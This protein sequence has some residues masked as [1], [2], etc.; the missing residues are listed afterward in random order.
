[1]ASFEA[2]TVSEYIAL[3]CCVMFRKFGLGISGKKLLG[4]DLGHHRGILLLLLLLFNALEF[5]LGGSSPYTS[6]N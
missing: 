6:N 3:F 4:P 5:S 1:M 2:V